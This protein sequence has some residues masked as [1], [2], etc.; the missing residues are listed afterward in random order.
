MHEL[1]SQTKDFLGQCQPFLIDGEWTQGAGS[2]TMACF[3]PSSGKQVGEIYTASTADVDRAAKAA[4]AA[5]DDKRWRGLTPAERQR[6]LLRVA[7]LI[8][9]ET[10]LL[11]ELEALNG[12]K[13]FGGNFHGEVP[14]SAETF[15]YYA[16]WV[17]KAGGQIFEPSVPGRHYHAFTREDPVGVAALITPWNGALSIACWKLAAALAAGCSCI[18]KPSELTPLSSLVLMRLMQEAGV[19]DG[20]VN[21]VPGAG[22]ELGAALLAHPDI[23]KLSFTGSTRVGQQ[24]IRDSAGDMTRLSLEL[25]GKS[26]VLIFNDADLEPTIATA[27]DAIFGNAGQV[28][29]AGS[30][31][32]AQRGVYEAVVKG[33]AE[34]ANGLRLGAALADDSGMGPL[35][36][37]A[38]RSSVAAKVDR[39]VA[40]GATLVTG[41]KVLDCEG[42]FYTPTV[43]TDLDHASEAVQE[44][45]FGPVAVI[46]PFDNE[47]DGIRLAN[48]VK[49][50][51]AASIWTRD[52]AKA[53]RVSEQ[54]EA[55]IIWI[56]DH[57]IPE[58]AMP[59]GGV[60]LSG[61]DREH[62]LHGLRAFTETKSVMMRL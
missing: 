45:I 11:A 9:R 42:N 36:S 50:G 12:G 55:G 4:K 10:L 7:D 39:A 16:G 2:T 17:T 41:G 35:I 56:N 13:L 53:L 32:Y 47:E 18:L 15:R 60:K 28:C 48:D 3:D 14:H 34:K 22:P 62:G 21:I 1:S 27:A 20:V 33:V 8:D 61:L 57:G 24:L 37:E 49:Y 5:F 52:A 43:L 51:L 30:R 31:I 26:P 54:L 6:I 19:P 25:G 46:I 29:V 44:E 23:A 38:H 58:L 40:E 59:I